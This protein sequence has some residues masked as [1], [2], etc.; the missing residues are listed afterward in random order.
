MAELLPLPLGEKLCPLTGSSQPLVPAILIFRS[1]AKAQDGGG[2]K[3]GFSFVLLNMQEPPRLCRFPP[4]NLSS[5]VIPSAC[6]IFVPLKCHGMM[7]NRTILGS[8]A[9]FLSPWKRHGQLTVEG[10]SW[11]YLGFSSC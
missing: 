11:L 1:L 6:L 8:V 9:W 2:T 10:R 7:E 4:L 3:L 5:V